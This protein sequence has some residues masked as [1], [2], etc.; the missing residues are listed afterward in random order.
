[1]GCAWLAGICFLPG[2][3]LL[4]VLCAMSCLCQG[5]FYAMLRAGRTRLPSTPLWGMVFGCLWLVY[6][7]VFPPGA[8]GRSFDPALF[9]TALLGISLFLFL[10]RALFSREKHSVPDVAVTLLGFFYLPFLLSFFIRLAQWGAAG[11]GRLAEDRR[12]VFLALFV[13]AVV[14]FGDVGGFAFGI[15]F[16]RHKLAPA[17]SPKKSWEGLAGGVFCSV[18]VG[19]G[20]ALLARAAAWL[21]GG[22]LEKMPLPLVAAVSAVLSVTGLLG[23]LIESRFK[24]EVNIK[25]SAGLLP[26]LGGFLDMFDSLIFTPAVFYFFLCWYE[27]VG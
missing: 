18:A 19:A 15:P 11:P 20:L 24:R 23:D 9:G 4:A 3:L 16:G 8:P 21:E 6:T 14:K 27:S 2:W 17:I 7:F 22:P 25:D 5:E 26:G 1:M 10:I 12:G 13:A